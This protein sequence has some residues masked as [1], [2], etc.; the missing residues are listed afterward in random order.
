MFTSKRSRIL[1]L[2]LLVAAALRLY[3]LDWDEGQHSHPD[4][5]WIAMVA[6]TIRWP[7][8][9]RDLLDPRRSTL[10]P[11]WEPERGEIR[12]FAYGHL[13]LYL[14]SLGGHAVAALGRRL[15]ASTG[16]A[17]TPGELGRELERYGDYAR[18]NVVGRLL[19]VIFDLGTILLVYRLGKAVYSEGV[20]LLAAAFTAVAVS[21]IQL[22]HFSTFDVIT[23]FFITL[24]LYGS[25]RVVRA[26]EEGRNV[27]WP[28]IWAGAAA[29][30]AVASK[31]S[32][33]PLLAVLGLAQVAALLRAPKPAASQ[34][35][36]L[37]A[38]GERIWRI[39]PR[40]A[41]S[42]GVALLAFFLTSPFALL[43]A[44]GYVK[45]IA[46]QSRMVRGLADWPFTRQYRNTTPFLY[47]IEQQVRWGLG[48]PLGIVAFAG[49]GWTIVRQFRRPRILEL[50]LL[51]WILPY[52]TLTGTFMV[53][54]MRYMLPLL[55]LLFIMGAALVWRIRDWARARSRRGNGRDRW[56]A[57]AVSWTPYL[58]LAL[59]LLY[60]LAFT[61]VYAQ[62]HPWIQVSRYIYDRVPD[63]SVIAVE[64]WDDHMP[65]SLPEDRANPGARG[66]RHVELPMYEPDNPD[67]L[68]LIRERLREADLIVLST[69]RL[70]RTIP[71]LPERYPVS[72]E[73][74]K[75]L[76][77]GKLGYVH[78]AEFTAYP[79][80]GN[81]IL[82]DDDADESFTVYDHPKPIVF[83]KVRD[84]ADSEWN[85]L[86]AE[87]LAQVPVW[88]NESELKL[89]E[90]LQAL[91]LVGELLPGGSPDGEGPGGSLLPRRQ[92]QEGEE[93]RSLLLDTPVG[94]LPIVD[95]YGWN[96][97]A[98]DST[99]A[100]VLLWWLAISLLGLLAW[101][102]T[103]TLW[104]GLRDR[105]YLLARIVALLLVGYLI[106]L[107]SSM[108]WLKNGLPLTYAAIGVLALVSGLLLWRG[109]K[110]MADW[111]R[112]NWR[113]VLL[114]EAVFGLALLA[115]VTI[116]LFNPDLWQPWQ[117]GEKLMDIA[118]LNS[119]MRSAYWPPPDP[120]YAQGYLNYYYYGQ[121]LLSIL[122]RLTGIRPTVGFNL[123][124]PLLFAFTVS[125][126]F[127]IGYSLAGGLGWG[128]KKG[129][130][131]A[132]QSRA[133]WSHGIAHGLL[134]VLC[135]A[136]VGN[137]ASITQVIERLGWVST[138]EFTSR[139]P[140]LQ[141]LVRAGTGLFAILFKG[142]RFSGF[143]Y[144]D[145]SRVVGFTINEF[146]Y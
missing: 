13:P 131:P 75:L 132:T 105:G 8:Q 118:Y 80:L 87:S 133:T 138:S 44:S 4:E 36:G 84:L 16:G 127:S 141:A 46:E 107:P 14:Q 53:K 21:H 108:R 140:G 66:Y 71:R 56:W 27:T 121:F 31:F 59:T 119:C 117:G 69:N 114:G 42:F 6:P 1:L 126:V 145:P 99:V 77:E 137:L 142:A 52:F 3:G 104:N 35:R 146:P 115:F 139:I 9:A 81:L 100:A 97:W 12:N 123:A 58:V 90:R 68:W 85:V 79:G 47:Q 72:T 109:G 40:L 125:S 63:G 73:F 70:Y 17:G 45:Q 34:A 93:T 54:F 120:Y 98:S 15:S 20:G 64:H 7:Q 50:I 88:E 51:G 67:K 134:A 110:Q 19:S 130:A 82:V 112:H 30:W 128:R 43:D 78:E 113:V 23:T 18:I 111:L 91:P 124:V 55:P 102:L 92:P 76:F 89:A 38:W 62:T 22:A 122:I 103:Y 116:R 37:Y 129:G 41:L 95:D 136:I 96:H 83:R 33:L 143:N 24:A 60:A 26:A 10:N 49:L 106:W 48:W 101:P 5:R 144:W 86:F 135:V 11:L 39:W 57:R 74:Y 65:L 28:T 61:R 2:I 94:E 25:V 29:G 32:A